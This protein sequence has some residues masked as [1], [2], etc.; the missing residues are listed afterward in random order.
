MLS[1]VWEQET[2]S[3][4]NRILL[5]NGKS[6]FF[7]DLDSVRGDCGCDGNKCYG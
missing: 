2:G 1:D 5:A 7:L 4:E 6:V 3:V